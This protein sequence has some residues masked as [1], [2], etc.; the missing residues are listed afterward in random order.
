MLALPHVEKTKTPGALAKHIA[1]A[2]AMSENI[3]LVLVSKM[4]W[5]IA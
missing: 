2:K 3:S 4:R 1:I 5:V